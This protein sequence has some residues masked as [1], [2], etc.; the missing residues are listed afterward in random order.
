MMVGKV[1]KYKLKGAVAQARTKRPESFGRERVAPSI[2]Y[3]HK[4]SSHLYDKI[5]DGNCF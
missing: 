1:V 2:L 5:T 3:A 4:N